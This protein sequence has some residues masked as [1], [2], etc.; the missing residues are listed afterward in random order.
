MSSARAQGGR[1]ASDNAIARKRTM[2]NLVSAQSTV[3]TPSPGV[4][5]SEE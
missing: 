3:F 4:V 2:D 1:T 5:D